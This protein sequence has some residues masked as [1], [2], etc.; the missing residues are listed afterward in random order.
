MS[1]TKTAF[2]K[3]DFYA[4]LNHVNTLCTCNYRGENSSSSLS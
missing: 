2:R 1:H 3:K 4:N